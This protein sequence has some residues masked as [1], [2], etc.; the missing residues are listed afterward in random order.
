MRRWI[1]I[2]WFVLM[3]NFVRVTSELPL[4]PTLLL[5]SNWCNGD[6]SRYLCK[7]LVLSY[8]SRNMLNFQRWGEHFWE[9]RNYGYGT[10]GSCYAET[11]ADKDPGLC[12]F[13][14]RYDGGNSSLRIIGSSGWFVVVYPS[15]WLHTA[16]LWDVCTVECGY[17]RALAS[18]QL[19]GSQE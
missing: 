16:T 7:N 14:E 6:Y 9:N 13:F 19:A 10:S 15:T 8:Y 12:I 2:E 1:G 4:L 5:V 17:L 3:Q 18:C 11:N